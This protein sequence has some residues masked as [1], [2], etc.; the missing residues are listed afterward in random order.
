MSN[1]LCLCHQIEGAVF[2]ELQHIRYTIRTMQIDIALLLTHEG[3]IT[4]GLEEFPCAD[5]VLH[6]TDIR[7][8]LDVEVTSIEETTHVQPW[9]KL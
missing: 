5:E 6:N 7:A 1:L 2:D 3:L 4:L 8:C 9:N